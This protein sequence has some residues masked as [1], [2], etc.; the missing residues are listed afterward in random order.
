MTRL[1]PP[2]LALALTLLPFGAAAAQERDW[3]KVEMKAVTLAENLVLIQGA[4][5]NLALSHGADGAVL[6]DDQYAPLHDK[7]LFQVRLVTPRAVRFVINTHWHG[8]HTGGNE[9]MGAIGA[10]VVAHDNVRKR[11]SV[12]QFSQLWDR[13]TPPSPPAALPIVTFADS[14]T[15]HVNGETLRVEHVA[16]AHTDGDSIVWFEKANVVHMGDV[17]F[18]GIYPRID[19]DAGGS[20]DGVIAATDQVLARVD[21]ATKIIPGHGELGSK[22]DLAAYR[23]VLVGIRAAVQKLIDAGKTEEETVAAKPTAPWDAEWGGGFIKPD[24]MTRTAYRSLTSGKG[25]AR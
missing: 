4:G 11:L 5:G 22:K 9:K 12:E 14:V 18:H 2:G 15:F 21:E 24:L 20:L 1:S 17:F 13:K 8:D 16:P 7:I 6:V 19:L 23:E 10:V 3:S 25:S